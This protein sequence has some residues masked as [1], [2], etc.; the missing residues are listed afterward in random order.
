M[1]SFPLRDARFRMIL[2]HP[3]FLCFQR[4]KQLLFCSIPKALIMVAVFVVFSVLLGSA[5]L[6]HKRS[7]NLKFINGAGESFERA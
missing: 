3:S 4:T 6:L 2:S 1:M 7:R 5:L